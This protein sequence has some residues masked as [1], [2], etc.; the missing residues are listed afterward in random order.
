MEPKKSQGLS[1]ATVAGGAALLCAALVGTAYFLG[2]DGE[3]VSGEQSAPAAPA[4]PVGSPA[5]AESALQMFLAGCEKPSIEEIADGRRRTR[6]TSE[7]NPAFL[8]EVIEQG[9]AI[10]SAKMLVPLGVTTNE[11]INWRRRGLEMFGAM[12]GTQPQAFLPT[13]FLD[14]IGA[15]RTVFVFEGRQYTTL[16]LPSVGVAFGVT[17]E[18]AESSPEK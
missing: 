17:P 11:I 7:E 6:C 13:E 8:L 16:P 9:D 12:A 15:S 2:G 4:T 18:G 5:S 1:L 3:E 14:A 10:Y